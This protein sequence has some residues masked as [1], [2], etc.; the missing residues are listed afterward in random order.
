MPTTPTSLADDPTTRGY[1]LQNV[2][3]ALIVLDIAFV[4]LRIYA[5]AIKRQTGHIDEWM[6]LCGLISNVGLCVV[7]ICEYWFSCATQ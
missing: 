3:I 2:A 5:R 7:A 1:I 6:V 4:A